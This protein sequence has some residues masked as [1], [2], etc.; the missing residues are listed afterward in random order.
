MEKEIKKKKEGDYVVKQLLSCNLSNKNLLSLYHH[1]DVLKYSNF[2]IE[3]V[4]RTMPVLWTNF[5]PYSNREPAY[6]ESRRLH[7]H[8]IKRI[9]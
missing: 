7:A 6:K 3:E 1:V 4:Q 5:G 8:D 2:W 9:Y